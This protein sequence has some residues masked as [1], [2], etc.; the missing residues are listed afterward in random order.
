MRCEA[1]S[2]DPLDGA[3]WSESSGG[4]EAVDVGVVHEGPGPGM[5]DG[6]D[7]RVTA[8]SL[9]VWVSGELEDGLSRGLEEERVGRLLELPD[10]EP[11]LLRDGEDD[12]EVG[13]WK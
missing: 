11:D 2:V 5:E 13:D 10:D 7:G 8:E 9:G 3:V 1:E 12:V 4:H 6:H